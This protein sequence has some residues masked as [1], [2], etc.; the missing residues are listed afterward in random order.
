VIEFG[1]ASYPAI[2]I[3]KR[4]LSLSKTYVLLSIAIAAN[5]ILVS[6]F[7]SNTM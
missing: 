5:G 7:G 4:G 6:S 3:V 2:I 1:M